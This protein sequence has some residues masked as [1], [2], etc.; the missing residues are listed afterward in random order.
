MTMFFAQI[1]NKARKGQVRWINIKVN[2]W[3][4]KKLYYLKFNILIIKIKILQCPKQ[5]DNVACGYFVMRY[6]RDIIYARFTTEIP[7]QV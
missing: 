7:P 3:L 2:L 4:L 1:N 6:M 5:L